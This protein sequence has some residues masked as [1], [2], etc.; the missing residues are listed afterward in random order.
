MVSMKL[1]YMHVGK[2]GKRNFIDWDWLEKTSAVETTEHLRVLH[3]D[4]PLCVRI[5]GK[6]GIGAILKPEGDWNL[7]P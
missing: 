3:L 4:E 1:A 5:N 2:P 6:T 7:K